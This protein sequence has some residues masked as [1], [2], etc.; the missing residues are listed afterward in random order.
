M[1]TA[2][3]GL[4]RCRVGAAIAVHDMDA[5]RAFYEGV[6]GLVPATGEEPAG[7]IAY[8]CGDGT[9]L[10]I[11]R[12]PHAS[13]TGATQAGFL[14]DDIAA[15]VDELTARGAT[16]VQVHEGDI[17]TDDRG[18]ARFGGTAAVAYLTDPEGNVL[19]LA[20]L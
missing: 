3:G 12:S 11:F 1:T 16:F 17:D 6:L 9:R 5:S 7:N 20:E 8:A 4:S 14:V 18:I 2:P 10:R 19:S 15:A 13:A